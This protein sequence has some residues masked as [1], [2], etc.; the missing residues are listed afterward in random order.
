MPKLSKARARAHQQAI[1]MPKQESLTYDEKVAIMDRYHEGAEHIQS[2]AG[3]FF[4]PEGL[5]RDFSIEVWGGKI[6]DLCAGIGKL[7][8]WCSVDRSD[9]ESLTCVEFNPDYVEVGKKLLPEANWICGDVL[10]VWRDLPNDF[11]CA[12]SN[13][14][15]G[16]IAGS[17]SAPRYTG[18]EFEYKVIDV[19][20]HIAK[21]GVFIL[22]QQSA[23]FDYSGR[24]G[25]QWTD[26]D[27]LTK[28]IEQTGIELEPNCGI[29]TATYLDDWNNVSPMVEI[30][31]CEFDREEVMA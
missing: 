17:G 25:L 31:C 29:D 1:K 19:A 16:R 27:K 11:D 10:E 23:P 5:A 7:A 6:V 20:S 24:N 9:I 14:P 21:S 13:P 30:V 26:I 4:T 2:T 3:A 22:P 12:I 28:F 8:F 18:A 15:F